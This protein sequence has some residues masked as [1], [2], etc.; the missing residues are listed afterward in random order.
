MNKHVKIDK[1]KIGPKIRLKTVLFIFWSFTFWSYGHFFDPL[2]FYLF[3]PL[4]LVYRT[5]SKWF[6]TFF[7]VRFWKVAWGFGLENNFGFAQ[8]WIKK[9]LSFTARRSNFNPKSK[10]I[11][12]IRYLNTSFLGSFG[13]MFT[14]P[15]C[16]WAR[17]GFVNIIITQ[18]I[19]IGSAFC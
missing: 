4:D 13:F 11:N 9:C 16:R 19:V 7:Q 2:V 18:E 6:C 3:G 14:K 10:S 1:F 17:S 8:T 15:R 12:F 5:S